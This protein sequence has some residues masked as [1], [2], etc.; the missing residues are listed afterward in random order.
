MNVEELADRII[1]ITLRCTA[2]TVPAVKKL[3]DNELRAALNEVEKEAY[4]RGKREAI[5]KADLCF[6]GK[7]HT[8]CENDSDC[9]VCGC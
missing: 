1:G 8:Y 2:A 4:E 6:D 5:E 9:C 7:P 3:V